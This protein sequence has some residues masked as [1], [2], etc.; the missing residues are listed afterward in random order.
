[1]AAG[2]L[3]LDLRITAVDTHIRILLTQTKFE[4]NKRK[5]IITTGYRGGPCTKSL[6]FCRRTKIPYVF[7]YCQTQRPRG[8]KVWVC[9]RSLPGIVGSNI[10]RGMDICFL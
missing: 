2:R 6:E 10:A 7:S 5:S 1:M 4:R 8:L 9:G 3:C